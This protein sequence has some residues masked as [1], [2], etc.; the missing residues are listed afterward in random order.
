M[1]GNGNAVQEAVAD[2]AIMVLDVPAKEG[3]IIITA[4]T[5]LKNEAGRV[6]ANIKGSYPTTFPKTVAEYM[7]K[8]KESVCK[9]MLDRIYTVEFQRVLRALVVQL[10]N[11]QIDHDFAVKVLESFVP[12]MALEKREMSTEEMASS[13]S[14]LDLAGKIA[15]FV[16]A[17]MDEPT[18]KR[19][20]QASMPK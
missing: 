17:G 1:S 10:Y 4:G 8:F 3:Q 9:T 13:F 18:A 20:A 5:G 6:T 14:S 2:G 11:K 12:F 16:A 15:F 7:S 19:M